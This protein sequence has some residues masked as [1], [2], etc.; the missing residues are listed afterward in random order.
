[1]IKLG[2]RKKGLKKSTCCCK[3]RLRKILNWGGWYLR[4][5][6]SISIWRRSSPMTAR[7]KNCDTWNMWSQGRTST[8]LSW[9]RCA[10][11]SSRL[12][13]RSCR[14]KKLPNEPSTCHLPYWYLCF[15]RKEM[16]QYEHLFTN[17]QPM[18]GKSSSSNL[19]V[20]LALG[21]LG[22]FCGPFLG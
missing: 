17:T 12:T 21:G 9:I 11:K 14:N 18:V 20:F 5:F 13:W 4:K 1:M 15:M 8:R 16:R 10:I 22:F 19:G 7:N 6:K 2:I 3:C